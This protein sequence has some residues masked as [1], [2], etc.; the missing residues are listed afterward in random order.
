MIFT[1]C[2]SN[3]CLV[4]INQDIV[5]SYFGARYGSRLIFFYILIKLIYYYLL[6]SHSFHLPQ[7]CGISVVQIRSL[8]KFE[9]VYSSSFFPLAFVLILK[10]CVM[11]IHNHVT[12]W[13]WQVYIFL[14]SLCYM[15]VVI[16][17]HVISL[18]LNSGT[19]FYQSGKKFY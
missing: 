5:I 19:K 1:C 4:L 16:Y 8:C 7:C 15:C 18:A 2:L 17:L 10:P 13:W 12:C 9:S 6:W 3:H 11:I 14:S